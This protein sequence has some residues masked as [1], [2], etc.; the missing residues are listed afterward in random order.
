[1]KLKLVL[2][3]VVCLLTSACTDWIFRIDV[4]QGNFLDQDDVNKLRVDMTK[5]QVIFVLGNPVVQ[6]SFDND[7]WYYVYDMKRGMRKRGEDIRKELVIT[8]KDNKIA[9]LDGDFETP[10]DFNTPLEQ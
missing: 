1:M 4:P 9:S 2:I 10:E 6:D 5:E 3:F 8:F 7:T